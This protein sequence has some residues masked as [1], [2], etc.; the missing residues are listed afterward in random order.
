V[1]QVK[2]KHPEMACYV[3][4]IHTPLYQKHSRDELHNDELHLRYLLQVTDM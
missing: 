3:R 1:E 4:K 2:T